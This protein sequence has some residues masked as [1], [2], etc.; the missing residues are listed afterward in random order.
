VINLSLGNLSESNANLLACLYSFTEQMMYQLY[1]DLILAYKLI[2]T[3][4][5]ILIIF[6]TKI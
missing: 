5:A 1:F 3:L 6:H 4:F 2:L